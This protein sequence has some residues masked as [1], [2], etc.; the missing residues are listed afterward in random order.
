MKSYDCEFSECYRKLSPILIKFVSRHIQDWHTAEEIVQEIFTYLYQKN[1]PMDKEPKALVGFLFRA[2]RNRIADYKR[3]QHRNPV[4]C[5]GVDQTPDISSISKIENR[6]VIKETYNEVN[7]M[8]NN[9]PQPLREIFLRSYR[10]GQ[11]VRKISRDMEISEYTISR[12]L[13]KFTMVVREK[14]GPLYF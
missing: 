9:E 1:E 11:A 2:A 3:K 13:K 14:I 5:S 10:D 7:R 12:V 8:I 4:L 6:V